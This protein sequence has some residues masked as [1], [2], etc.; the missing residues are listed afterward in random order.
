MIEEV[1]GRRLALF[2]AGFTEITPLNGKRPFLKDWQKRGPTNEDEIAM[3]EQLYPQALNTG[4]LTSRVPALDVD[5]VSNQEACDAIFNLVEERFEERGY[6]L[7]RIGKPPKFCIPFRTDAPFKKITIRFGDERLEFLGTG[8]QFVV[9]GI[10][11]DTGEPY[12]WFKSR[13]DQIEYWDLPF[14]GAE[15]AQRLIDD[16]SEL[17]VRDFRFVRSSKRR[18]ADEGRGRGRTNPNPSLNGSGTGGNSNLNPINVAAT[19]NLDKWVPELFPEA[20]ESRGGYRVTSAMLGRDLQEDLSIMPEG[21]VD[22]GVADMGDAR[23]G[24][25]TAIELVMEYANKNYQDAAA[26]LNLKLFNIT[27]PEWRDLKDR[28]GNPAQSLANTV[29]A[30]KTLGITCRMDLFHNVVLVE[31]QGGMVEIQ[32]LIGELTDNTLGGIRSLINNQFRFDP[33]DPHTFA[34]VKEIARANAF[35]PILDYLNEVQGRWDGVERIDNWLADYCGAPDTPYTRAIGRKHLIASVRRARRPGCKYDDILVMESPEGKNKSTAIAI[36]AGFENFSDQTIL[37]V[38]DRVMQE[39]ITGVWLY[40]IADLTDIA[41]ADVNR[42]KAFASRTTDRARPAYGRITERRPR[43]C[44]FWATTND[45]IYLK[46]QTGNRRFV[47]TPVGTIAI[48]RLERDRDQL[49]A[50]AA[51]AEAADESIFLNES[52]WVAAAEEQEKRRAVDPWECILEQI[53]EMLNLG[54]SP[55]PRRI[56]WT[57]DGQERVA[58]ADLLTYVLKIPVFQQSSTHWQRLA[59]IMERLGWRRP[60]TTIRVNSIP[61]RGYWRLINNLD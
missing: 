53:P 32:T 60:A 50:E 41:R 48:D 58:S 28:Y 39:L 36:L 30:I 24:K 15:E 34:A 38:D 22:F 47:P 42:V 51:V 52:L 56:V 49:W 13:L 59:V 45:F 10:H 35:D 20:I 44:T 1:T 57:A 7:R 27:K 5:I 40:E 12:R 37:G 14:I 46:S 6:V 17:L 21:I 33:G 3:W 26:W 29:I 8:Q 23:E 19:A 61:V 4:L 11:P 31:Y 54:E 25:R 16:A 9:D 2:R 18:E 55:E 43:R